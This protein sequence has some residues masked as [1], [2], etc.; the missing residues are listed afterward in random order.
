[1]MALAV[2]QAQRRGA[3]VYRVGH[4][5]EDSSQQIF[6]SDAVSSLADV[7]L[8]GAVRPVVICGSLPP[9]AAALHP[10]VVFLLDGPNAF[11]CGLLAK[12]YK[13]VALSSAIAEGRVKGIVSFEADLPDLPDL[14]TVIGAADWQPTEV[15]ARAQVVLPST[16]WVEQEGIFVNYEGRAQCFKKALKPGLPIKGLSPEIHPPRTFSVAA[17]GSDVAPVDKLISLLMLRMEKHR[18][19]L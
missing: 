2:R 14:I 3:R 15:M 4:S 12:E 8:A 9:D 13:A 7:P 10:Q 16:A 19:N 5:V 11:G 1:M 6:E 17:P 18:L